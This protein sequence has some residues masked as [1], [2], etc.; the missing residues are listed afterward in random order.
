MKIIAISNQ[1][2]GCGK[3]TTSINLCACLASNALKVL[4]IDLD[5]QAHSTIGLGYDLRGA[6]KTTYN[7]L[8]E[9]EGSKKSLE[10]V[11][12]NLP[13]NFDL[14]PSCSILS[15]IEQEFTDIP[16]GVSRLHEKIQ[17]SSLSYDYMVIDSPPSLG[18]LTFN[19]LR[20]SDLIIVPIDIGY[21]SLLGVDNLRGLVKLLNFTL[22]HN[23]EV[24]ILATMYDRRT[25]FS[26][27]I[28]NILKDR[29]KDN[30]L[31][32]YI[33]I[34]TALKRASKENISILRYD[35]NANGAKD[36]HT[37]TDELLGKKPEAELEKTQR[38]TSISS[39]NQNEEISTPTEEAKE[40]ETEIN[41]SQNGEN[42]KP[43]IAEEIVEGESDDKRSLFK[44]HS[45]SYFLRGNRQARHPDRH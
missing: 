17:S 22:G 20:A 11:I 27:E 35:K 45:V 16:K 42:N 39:A 40:V 10:E 30:L 32:T 41:S 37:L 23:P 18:F 5:P 25:K 12:I 33:R 44:K 34:N 8:T 31:A 9:K 6:D 21:Y 38:F 36:Y 15:I 29:F 2:G 4:L 26:E 28:L 24:K 7:V 14:A 43:S 3:T 13:E 1:K 19:A